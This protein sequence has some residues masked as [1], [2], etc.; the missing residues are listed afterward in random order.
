[1]ELRA[2]KDDDPETTSGATRQRVAAAARPPFAGLAVA[3]SSPAAPLGQGLAWLWRLGPCRD[4]PAPGAVGLGSLE[5]APELERAVRRGE[6]AGAIVFAGESGAAAGAVPARST[7]EG[8][9]RLKGGGGVA[10][11]H[12]VFDHAAGDAAASSSLGAHAV[13]S[14]ALLVV[15]GDAGDLWG[16]LD[17]TW[18]LGPI[19]RFLLDLIGRPLVLLPPVGCLRFD[20]VPATGQHQLEGRAKDD[21]HAARLVRRMVQ[22]LRSAR[23]Q[24]VVAVASQA[25]EDDVPR[26]LDAVY[27][28]SVAALRAGV[29]AGVLEPACHGTVHLDTDALA[30]GE[31]E[32]REFARLSQDEAGRRLDSALAWM[33]SALG[34][35]G[36]FVAPAWGYSDGT[37]AAAR[38]RGL[39]HWLPPMPGPL[40]QGLGFHE[41]LIDGLPGLHRLDYSPLRALTAVGLPP[42]VVFHGRLLD[43]RR[44]DLNPSRDLV[45]LARLAV[46]RDLTRIPRIEGVRWIGAREL[47]TRLREH[48]QTE[49]VEGRVEAPPGSQAVLLDGAGRRKLAAAD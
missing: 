7:L 17:R 34:E 30:G 19:A 40:L 31:I 20:D 8:V 3:P 6:L 32:P 49:V 15:G 24:L 42:T 23:A 29:D 37:L 39:A 14:G 46:R 44:S 5:E 2:S 45:P 36:S 38:A 43:L 27:P 12:V 10:G 9:A 4:A 13:R 22:S 47:V 18:L 26:P 21:A 33:R 16:R 28:R 11:S 48:E 1:M 25:F 41:T 35:P